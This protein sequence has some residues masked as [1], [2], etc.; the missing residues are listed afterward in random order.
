M[1][2]TYNDKAQLQGEFVSL[3]ENFTNNNKVEVE[4]VDENGENIGTV[5]GIKEQYALKEE[6]TF[7]VTP[8][9]G[10]FVKSVKLLQGFDANNYTENGTL[11]TIENGQYSFNANVINKVVVEFSTEE[12]GEAEFNKDVSSK[13][14]VEGLDSVDTSTEGV[15]TI[16]Y[17]LNS[18]LYKN[19]KLYR[20][21]VVESGENNE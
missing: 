2:I 14:V 4:F 8:K 16:S 11:L 9:E 17:T 21:I 5:T 19:V 15:Y 12:V 1:V 20:Y 7:T 10:Y 18:S 6:V 3:D 13:V